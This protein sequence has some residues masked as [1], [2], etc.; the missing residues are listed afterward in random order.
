MHVGTGVIFQGEGEG[1]TDRDVYAHEMRLADLAEPLGF[2]SLWG[3]EHHFTSYTMCPDV[4]QYLAYF[5]GR[6][7]HIRL[8]SMVVVLPWHHPMRVAEEVA[9]LDHMSNGR[10]ILGLGRGL[11]RIEFEGLGVDQ[12]DSREL[13]EE[14]TEMLMQGLE[15]GYCEYDG[16]LIKQL[17]RDIRP[18]P[19]AS[20][21]GRTYAAAVSP[22]SSPIIARLGIGMLINPQKPWKQTLIDL[23]AYREV[24]RTVHGAEAP[25][26]LLCNWTYC[27]DDAGRVEELSYRYIGAYYESVARHYEFVGDHLKNIRGYEFYDKMQ[28]R[29]TSDGV[30]EMAKFFVNLQAWGTPTQCYEKVVEM[31]KL[32]AAEGYVA[33][34]S[35][36][37]MPYDLAEAS[38]R[39]FAREVAPELRKIVPAD[40]QQIARTGLAAEA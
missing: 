30:A 8:G 6:T 31:Q 27:D 37:G 16:R 38:M 25:P 14:S 34:F 24:F 12:N 20:F 26:P 10:Y 35:F 1:R 19:F 17:R 23:E 22:E 2:D 39:R 13:F 15:R 7:R 11:G 40:Q 33:I 21:R 9:M 4:L 29:T 3:V 28:R 18:R 5:A 32:T 36:G